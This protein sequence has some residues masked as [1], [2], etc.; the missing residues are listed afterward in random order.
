MQ[1]CLVKSRHDHC[2]LNDSCVCNL[3]V[4]E[5]EFVIC[6]WAAQTQDRWV[7]SRYR[8]GEEPRC[9]ERGFNSVRVS[10]TE[11]WWWFNPRDDSDTHANTPQS[12][13]HWNDLKTFSTSNTDHLQPY[14][15]NLDAV[16]THTHLKVGEALRVQKHKLKNHPES[17]NS[18]CSSVTLWAAV[19]VM[20]QFVLH[21]LT[22]SITLFLW[23]ICQYSEKLCEWYY[24]K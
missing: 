13:C 5:R 2:V 3:C 6:P 19:S 21:S 12:Q 10:G 7:S 4:P 17:R 24:P 8:E 18:V 15:V 20:V 22:Y 1:S 14:Q 11:W 16:M 23:C 9:R